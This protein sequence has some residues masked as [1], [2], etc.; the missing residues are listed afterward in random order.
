MF[1]RLTPQLTAQTQ[2]LLVII[3]FRILTHLNRTTED[4]IHT[5][6]HYFIKTIPKGTVGSETRIDSK[7]MCE[8]QRFS[9]KHTHTHAL[10]IPLQCG[11]VFACTVERTQ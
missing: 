9:L 1:K 7:G 8:L 3:L 11:A 10:C 2:C 4:R 6:S 5:V